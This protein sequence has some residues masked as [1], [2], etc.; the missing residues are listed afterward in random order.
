MGG[1]VNPADLGEDIRIMTLQS[2]Q[3]RNIMGGAA[4]NNIGT[5]Q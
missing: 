5:C 1:G 4:S 3:Y 2:N